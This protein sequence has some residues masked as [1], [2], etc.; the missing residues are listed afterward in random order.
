MGEFERSRAEH[1][2]C[3]GGY[4]DDVDDDDVG[5]HAADEDCDADGFVGAVVDV[6]G[7][8]AADDDE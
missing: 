1:L 7:A 6:V 8:A 2:S 4:H 3:L 5:E